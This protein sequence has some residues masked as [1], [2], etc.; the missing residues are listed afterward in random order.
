[1]S[2]AQAA[3]MPDL[4][5]IATRTARLADLLDA[6]A[7]ESSRRRSP[8]EGTLWVAAEY[9]IDTHNRLVGMFDRDAER[10]A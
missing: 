4:D 2:A 5:V 8:N 6:L 9:A 1:M 10:Q 7:N 3:A